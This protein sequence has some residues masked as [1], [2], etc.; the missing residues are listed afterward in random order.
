M[1]KRFTKTALN[2]IVDAHAHADRAEVRYI[3]TEHLL[4]ALAS[5]DTSVAA[6]LMRYGVTADSIEHE[7]SR[8][9]ASQENPLEADKAALADLGIDLDQIRTAVETTFGPGAL[10]R[11]RSVTDDSRSSR[12][13]GRRRLADAVSG[14]GA[15][16]FSRHA[17]KALELSLRA[18]L[19][20]KHDFISPEHLLLGI[21][22][23][24]EGL[25]F[26]I[27]TRPDISLRELKGEIED[28]IRRMAA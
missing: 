1:F 7:Q 26:T 23:N 9:H 20:L 22:A 14:T 24:Q 28:S 5:G 11:A 15:M 2:V 25:G 4:L 21:L 19:R 3:G 17:K 10:E 16:P 8:A 27:L 13:R 6:L 12:R 18:A